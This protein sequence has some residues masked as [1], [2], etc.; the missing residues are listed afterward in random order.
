[1]RDSTPFKICGVTRRADAA[2]AEA[3]GAAYVGANFVPASPRRVE[4]HVAAAL[5]RAI[6]IPL[7][8][9]VADLGPLEAAAIA[10]AAGA[11]GIQ[12]HGTEP[13]E[14]VEALRSE[15]GWE[16][17][18]A[19]RVRSPADVLDAFDRFA[20]VDLLLLDGWDPSRLGGTGAP[21]DWRAVES[22]RRDAP[23]GLRVGIAGGITPENVVEAIRL[24][25]PDL[26][27]VASGVES[28][29]GVKDHDRIRELAREIRS[30]GGKSG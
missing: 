15:G 14:T 9:V 1:V 17:W 8:A 16:L 19:V 2:A 7:V 20:S 21:F 28:A 10:R 24:L 23:A 12:L 3:A 11:R 30:R 29:P 18:K 27:D 26:V 13:P 22:V 4:A 5:A 25:Q 6:S